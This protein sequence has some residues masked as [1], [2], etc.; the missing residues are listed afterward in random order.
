MN[1][2]AKCLGKNQVTAKNACGN[3]IVL[4][5]VCRGGSI[6][7]RALCAMEWPVRP[8][9]RAFYFLVRHINAIDS[10]VVKRNESVLWAVWGLCSFK[11][12]KNYANCTL[13][14]FL[15]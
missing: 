8:R 4:I 3:D 13:N 12:F 1:D 7:C 6:V 14:Y 11:L 5:L 15:L 10:I 9:V 2:H